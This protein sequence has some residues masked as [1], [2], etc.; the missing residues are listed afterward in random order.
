MELHTKR[1][2]HPGYV[3][4]GGPP[5]VQAAPGAKMKKELAKEAKEKKKKDKADG[6]KKI[7]AI[8]RA[9]TAAYPND[10]TPR[11]TQMSSHASGRKQSKVRKPRGRQTVPSSES[12]SE[13]TSKAPDSEGTEAS[14]RSADDTLRPSSPPRPLLPRR[15]LSRVSQSALIRIPLPRRIDFTLA[16][17]PVAAPAIWRLVHIRRTSEPT[18][19]NCKSQG[20][21]GCYRQHSH[22]CCVP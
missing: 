5:R 4:T 21:C 20:G 12:E 8:E 6:L 14:G 9:N 11:S 10:A 2:S 13:F 22:A 7:A 19:F 18:T 16:L 15:F 17:A 1:A 3:Q